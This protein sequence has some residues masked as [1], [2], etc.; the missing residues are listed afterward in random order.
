M[1]VGSRGTSGIKNHI[2]VDR[3]HKL[4]HRYAEMDASAPRPATIFSQPQQAANTTRSK[5]CARLSVR[6]MGGQSEAA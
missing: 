5:V 3:K 4:I 2:R 6:N 1:S